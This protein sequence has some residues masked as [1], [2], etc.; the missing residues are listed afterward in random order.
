MLFSKAGAN[1]GTFTL[2]AKLLKNLAGNN[3]LKQP[4]KAP[5]KHVKSGY[6]V[7]KKLVKRGE[8]AWKKSG[9]SMLIFHYN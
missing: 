4:G 2:P 3:L 6:K 7:Q 8:Q 5:K 1:I 9:K